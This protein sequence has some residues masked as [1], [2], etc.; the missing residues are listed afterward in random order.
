LLKGNKCFAHSQ[1]LPC[2]SC[3]KRSRKQIRTDPPAEKR[4]AQKISHN[5]SFVLVHESDV[6][7]RKKKEEEKGM[8]SKQEKFCAS[9]DQQRE[10]SIDVEVSRE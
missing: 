8:E 5:C 7:R 10:P 3:F 6:T 4:Y 2:E 1:I 9:Q